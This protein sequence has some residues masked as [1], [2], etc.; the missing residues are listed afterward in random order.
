MARTITHTHAHTHLIHD[1]VHTSVYFNVQFS[2]EMFF[3]VKC[4]QQMLYLC[5]GQPYDRLPALS[6]HPSQPDMQISM[7][8]YSLCARLAVLVFLCEVNNRRPYVETTSVHDL[9]PHTKPCVGFS[10]I[11]VYVFLI[12][13]CREGRLAY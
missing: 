10:W 12:K 3:S 6:E 13:S 9:L 1:R 11:L 2:V 5:Y 8:A 4:R 7:K